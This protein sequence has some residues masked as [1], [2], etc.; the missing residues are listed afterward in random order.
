MSNE[1]T[2][3][4]DPRFDPRFQRGYVPDAAALAADPPPA[5]VVA[6]PPAARAAAVPSASRPADPRDR[7][8]DPRD[9]PADADPADDDHAAALL[10]YFGPEAGAAPAVATASAAAQPSPRVGPPPTSSAPRADAAP[11]PEFVVEPEPVSESPFVRHPSLRF[12]L[13]LAAS[14]SFVI[15]GTFLYWNVNIQQMRGSMDVDGQAVLQASGAL[16]TGLAQAGA[17]GV[18]VVLAVWAASSGRRSRP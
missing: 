10:A 3:G 11:S 7:P 8:A 5:A 1:A 12:W 17:L 13:G 4:I 18:V 16:A 15:V 2:R 14:T 9:R 6:E